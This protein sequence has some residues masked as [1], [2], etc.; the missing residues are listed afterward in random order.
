MWGLEE[1]S[2]GFS[3]DG[4]I[5]TVPCVGSIY[6]W[7]LAERFLLKTNTAT[8][9]PPPHCALGQGWRPLWPSF[10]SLGLTCPLWR[11]RDQRRGGVYEH[12]SE[13]T[14]VPGLGPGRAKLG[15][16][17][18]VHDLNFPDCLEFNMV[19][20]RT[21]Q[22]WVSRPASLGQCQMGRCHGTCP[23]K[24]FFPTGLALWNI[25]GQGLGPHVPHRAG[26]RLQKG[27]ET[28]MSCSE[29]AGPLCLGRNRGRV[30]GGKERMKEMSYF[31]A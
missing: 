23:L 21:P 1:T 22:S 3:V 28:L 16:F 5:L 15:G 25:K 8:G 2:P 7:G 14:V 9:Y 11:L 17:G 26:Q 19:S 6:I 12:S 27:R 24:L 29:E 20:L 30:A 31:R 18:F 4:L 13:S 10:Q